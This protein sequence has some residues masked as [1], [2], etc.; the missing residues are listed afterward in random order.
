[1]QWNLL[2][3][4]LEIDNVSEIDCVQV[5][6]LNFLPFQIFGRRFPGFNIHAIGAARLEVSSLW[7]AI[8]DA[9]EGQNGEEF[10]KKKHS[11]MEKI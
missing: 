6:L 8:C 2:N 3:I 11:Q 9:K 10:T 5:D 1:M 4:A 7:E